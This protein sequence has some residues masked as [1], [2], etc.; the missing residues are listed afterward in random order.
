MAVADEGLAE[1]V[2]LPVDSL[3]G[4]PSANGVALDM[5]KKPFDRQRLAPCDEGE[6]EVQLRNGTKTCWIGVTYSADACRR[7]GYEWK[8]GCY[9]PSIPAPRTPSSTR[10][11]VEPTVPARR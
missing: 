9:L 7:K 1:P 3:D 11:D 8:G 5:P 2:A 10:P 6:T 4:S